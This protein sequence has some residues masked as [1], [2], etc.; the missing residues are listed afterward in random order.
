[1][2]SV[3]NSQPLYDQ[4]LQ[5]FTYLP[6]AARV[7]DAMLCVH[8]GIGP[9]LVGIAD[10]ATVARPIES[11]TDPRVMALVWSDPSD[12]IDTFQPSPT[13]GIGFAFGRVGL[14]AFLAESG[15]QTLV[16]AHE[17]ALNGFAMHFGGSCITVFSASNYCGKS[18]NWA[19]ILQ[20]RGRSYNVIQFQPLA[21]LERKDVA[22]REAAIARTKI[23]TG[24]IVCR[25]LPEPAATVIVRKDSQ[26]RVQALPRFTATQAILTAAS[27]PSLPNCPALVDPPLAVIAQRSDNFFSP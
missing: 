9:A 5:A 18:G 8:G 12:S 21:W 7:G 14:A 20:V 3:Y 17:F 22:F 23:R 4:A 15:C 16:R 10:V 11:S 27:T 6:L 13:R 2:M 24:P 25:L 26:R 19:A 1:M